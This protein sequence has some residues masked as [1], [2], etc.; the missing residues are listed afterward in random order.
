[1][2]Y[3]G[4]AA[5]RQERDHPLGRIHPETGAN[6]I[7]IGPR[8]SLVDV[9][10]EGMSDELDIDSAPFVDRRFEGEDR[11]NAI[12]AGGQ[13]PNPTSSPR[14]D[15]GSHVVEH[16][17]PS[18]PR[19][20]REWKIEAGRVDEHDEIWIARLQFGHHST[21]ASDDSM[22]VG[23]DF[24]DATDRQLSLMYDELDPR[25]FEFRTSQT[26]KAQA[27]ASVSQRA[28][29]ICRVTIP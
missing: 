22:Q 9:F 15:L 4:S 8:H 10:D 26:P 16:R 13:L 20:P 1:V 25:L 7:A 18:A 23:N 17:N 12:D 28:H 14:P 24:E 5:S 2:A 11:G 21:P 29:E 19:T 3:L 6:A 27:R